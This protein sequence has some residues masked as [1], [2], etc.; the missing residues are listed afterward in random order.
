MC[1]TPAR[2]RAKYQIPDPAALFTSEQSNEYLDGL[3]RVYFLGFDGDGN[4]AEFRVR[5]YVAIC[6]FV[7]D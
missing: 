7:P 4:N 3:M 2:Q 6:C 5:V 1:R